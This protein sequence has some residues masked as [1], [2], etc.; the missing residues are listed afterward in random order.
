MILLSIVTV[1]LPMSLNVKKGF[2]LNESFFTDMTIYSIRN[3]Y[4]K[5]IKP[6]FDIAMINMG[7][8]SVNLPTGSPGSELSEGCYFIL[9]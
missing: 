8:R 4:I 2:L 9:R 1:D 6:I 7:Q 5:K 3:V